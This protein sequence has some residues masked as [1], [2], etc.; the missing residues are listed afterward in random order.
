MSRH[1]GYCFTD[2]ELKLDW[3]DRLKARAKYIIVGSEVCPKTGKSHWQGYVCLNESMS[4]TAMIKLMRPRHV[5]AC[6]G[7]Q[8]QNYQYCSKDGRLI[9][10]YGERTA[11]GH[12]A[13]LEQVA[14][15]VK[16]KTATKEIAS[17]FPT[18]FIRYHKGIKALQGALVYDETPRDWATKVTVLWG[19]SGSGKTRKARELG[20]VIID[21]S[22]DYRFCLNYRNQPTVIFDDFDEAAA[23]AMGRQKFLRLTD[24]YEMMVEIKGDAIQWNPKH[25]I[26][27][28]NSA[29]SRWFGGNDP[30]VARRISETTFMPSSSPEVDGG[31]ILGPP[32]TEERPDNV[33][34][35]DDLE[36][37]LCAEVT[38]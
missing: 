28:S 18:E 32:S 34:L 21:W 5:E 8:D 11:Q 23:K 15:M 12:R 27:T 13:D 29:P 20:G 38:K 35:L 4:K 31:V 2:Y 1:R 26:I 36:A 3:Y 14:Y 22:P 17:G 33:A 16:Q 10:E 25:I 19:E 30:A 9:L 24:R 7:N 37:L 6:Q